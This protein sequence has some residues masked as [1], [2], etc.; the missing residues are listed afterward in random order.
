[1][2]EYKEIYTIDFTN[3]KYYIDVH[4]TIREAFDW[5]EYYGCN[6]SAFWD[7]LTNMLGRQIHI[8]IIGIEI[9]RKKFGDTADKMIE[10][11]RDFKNDDEDYSDDIL[12]E[13]VEGDKRVVIE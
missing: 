8:E 9:L 4:E 3:I 12:I 1:M 13:V 5:P 11:L 10:I 7:F 2:Y 6:W